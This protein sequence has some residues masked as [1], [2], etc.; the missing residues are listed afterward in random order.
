MN[1]S[2][3]TMKPRKRPRPTLA[4]LV[5]GRIAA[6]RNI[7][8]D[9]RGRRASFPS[10]LGVFDEISERSL[11]RTDISDH[12]TT[13]FV[14]S[15]PVRPSVI[16]ELGVRGGES[17]F[18]FERVAGL[19]DAKLV[20]VDIEDCSRV[21]AYR[22]WSFIKSDDIAFAERFADWCRSQQIAPAID[23]LFID[24]SH[25]FEH[26][27]KELT[28]WFPLLSSQC[29]VFMHD[30]NMKKMFVRSDGSVGIGWD[31]RRGVIAALESYL[32]SRFNEELDFTAVVN[33]WLI[34]HRAYCCGLTILERLHEGML[35]A[36]VRS[37]KNPSSTFD[38][39]LQSLISD[40]LTH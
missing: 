19:Y 4:D 2:I 31:N 14:E 35:T 12:L 8:V 15:L 36:H 3:P 37:E 13:L 26:T 33:G 25:E 18:V 24:T 39:P 30:T 6:F 1:S 29:K 40:S 20:S 5:R 9:L 28:C 34:K 7:V 10:S 27:L 22:R 21:S 32:G 38:R 17:T 16:V 11:N 23:I